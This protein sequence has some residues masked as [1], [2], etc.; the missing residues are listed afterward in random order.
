[1]FAIKQST[2][3]SKHSISAHTSSQARWRRRWNYWKKNDLTKRSKKW[4]SACTQQ[5][6]YY[7]SSDCESSVSTTNYQRLTC[8]GAHSDNNTS[9]WS[10]TRRY[11]FCITPCGSLTGAVHYPSLSCLFQGYRWFENTRFIHGM[12]RSSV[13]L[14][15]SNSL[16]NNMSKWHIVRWQE[17]EWRRTGRCPRKH[18]SVS[19]P[20]LWQRETENKQERAKLSQTR[21]LIY[22]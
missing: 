19:W 17:V 20:Q 14:K 10:E 2:G 3:E 15:N 7:C 12:S 6:S 13:A 8:T 16:V 9:S 18:S 4:Q 11:L 22:I 21:S 5:I 1:M